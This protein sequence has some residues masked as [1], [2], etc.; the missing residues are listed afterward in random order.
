MVQEVLSVDTGE[1]IA[2]SC[3]F[4]KNAA[5]VAVGGSDGSIRMIDVAKGDLA[6][7]LKGHEHSVNGVLF[8]QDN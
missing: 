6:A 4:D 2:H 3:A 1:N 5:A 8:N 7:E